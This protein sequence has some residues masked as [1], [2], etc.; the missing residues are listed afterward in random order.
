MPRSGNPNPV[1][2]R[3]A[4]RAAR[5]PAPGTVKQLTAVLWRAVKHLEAHIEARAP[6]SE[7]D[8]GEVTKLVHALSQAAGVYLRAIEV[9]ELEGRVEALEQGAK[10]R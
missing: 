5:R 9:G 6:H 7:A 2:G 3:Q 10:D 4:K 8:V 1:A